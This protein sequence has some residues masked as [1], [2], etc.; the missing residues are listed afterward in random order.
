LFWI[1][2]QYYRQSVFVELATGVLIKTLLRMPLLAIFE[3][4][5]ES[6]IDTWNCKEKEG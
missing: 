3:I 2:L 6:Y 1:I 4:Y 5:L